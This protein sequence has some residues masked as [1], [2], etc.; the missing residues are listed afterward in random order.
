MH[1]PNSALAS[2]D[3]SSFG[4]KIKSQANSLTRACDCLVDTRIV[5]F[6][7]AALNGA[8]KNTAKYTWLV[9]IFCLCHPQI[10]QIAAAGDGAVVVLT[11]GNIF[12]ELQQVAPPPPFGFYSQR[13]GCSWRSPSPVIH[14]RH[15]GGAGGFPI[16]LESRLPAW[17]VAR[18]DPLAGVTRSRFPFQACTRR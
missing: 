16:W 1:H 13:F 5:F 6:I 15:G 10:S 17:Q 12:T 7:V 9:Q 14:A 18:K 8:T 3:H 11:F 4:M 2:C